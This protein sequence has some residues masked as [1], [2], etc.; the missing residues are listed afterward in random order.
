MK[1]LVD[2]HF[3]E[4]EISFKLKLPSFNFVELGLA[5]FSLGYCLP[6]GFFWRVQP[7]TWHIEWLIPQKILDQELLISFPRSTYPLKPWCFQRSLL[8]HNPELIWSFL[9]PVESIN[10]K[11][12]SRPLA[13]AEQASQLSWQQVWLILVQLPFEPSQQVS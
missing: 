12:Q 11:D 13:F 2:Q 5:Q 6:E 4:I 3:E 7:L 10:S 8:L 9:G 1:N